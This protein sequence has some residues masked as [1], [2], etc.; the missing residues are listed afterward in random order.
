MDSYLKILEDSLLKKI[1]VLDDIAAYNEE[2][3]KIFSEGNA[4]IDK[5]DEYMDKKE[6]L[7]N[8]LSRLDEGFETLYE[9][10]AEQLKDNKVLY[11]RQIKRLQQ[12]VKEI[13]D[14]SVSIQAQEARNK[15]LIEEYF[16]K[17][18]LNLRNNRRTSKAAYDYYKSMSGISS[19]QPQFM[20]SKQ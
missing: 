14:K 19:A 9:R 1:R 10:V 13:T 7:I 17:E 16:A 8:A 11:A 6:E 3:R 4:D 20:D 15:T 18:R 5:F 2:Q 12:L